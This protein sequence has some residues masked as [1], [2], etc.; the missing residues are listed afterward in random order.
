MADDVSG[1][2]VMLDLLRFAAGGGRRTPARAGPVADVPAP[3]RRRGVLRRGR[4][5]RARRRRWPGVG[6]G[7]RPLPRP[8]GVLPHG[9]R[10]GYP[11]VTTLRTVP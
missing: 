6:R 3:L 10:P 4:R 1:P 8:P 7:R 9:R 5:N 2:V 11:R